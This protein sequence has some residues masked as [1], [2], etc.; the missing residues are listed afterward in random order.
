MDYGSLLSRSWNI[1][2]NNKFLFVLGF[3]AALGSGGSSGGGGGSNSGFRG[4]SSSDFNLPPDTIANMQSFLAQYGAL[5]LGLVCFFFVLGIVLWLVR[6]TAQTGL[7]DAVS[8]IDAGEKVTFGDAFA[9]GTSKLGRMVGV[10]L[11]MFGPFVLLALLSAGIFLGTAGTAF[12]KGTVGDGNVDSLFAG[13]GIFA[14]CFGLLA[15][16]L[17]PVLLVVTIVY[18][19]AQRGAVLRD[20]SVMDSVRHGWQ[21]VRANLG[22]VFILAILFLVIGAVFGVV[23][24]IVLIPGAVLIFIPAV[25]SIFTRGISIGLLEIG[26]LVMGGICLALLAAAVNSVLTAFRSTAVTLAYQE[27]SSKEKSA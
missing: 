22:E 26:Y 19:F 27:F 14:V 24:L 1:V 8:R 16:L 20:L 17:L 9:A 5:M 6:L 4:S 23:T 3:L 18:P 15:C 13:M 21:V 25:I 11:L 10:N 2:W 7:I 12:Y